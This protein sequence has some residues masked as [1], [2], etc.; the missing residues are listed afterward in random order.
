MSEH[1]SGQDSRQGKRGRPALYVL[2]ISVG[3]MLTSAVGLMIWQGA[4]SP[5]DYASQSQAASRK[6]ITG[7]D[8]GKSDTPSSANSTGVPEGNPAYPQP[9]VRSVNP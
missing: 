7:S 2:I 3:L 4:N 1:T 9:A 6:Q 5:P 8:T